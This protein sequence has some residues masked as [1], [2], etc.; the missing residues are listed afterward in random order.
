MKYHRVTGPAAGD[1]KAPYHPARAAHKAQQHA[2]HFIAA[3]VA[4]LRR[5][6]REG[7]AQDTAAG[8]APRPAEPPVIVCPYDAELF[9]HWW[10]E[11]PQWLEAVLRGLDAARSCASDVVVSTTTLGAYAAAH[12]PTTEAELPVSSWGRGGYA[13]V[14]LQPRSQWVHPQL[15]AAE[16]RMLRLARKHPDDSI[17]ASLIHRALNQ[18]ARELM[19]AQ[20]SDWTFILDAGTVT[21]YA[22][23]RINKHLAQF[24]LLLDEI[25]GIRN[26]SKEE[27]FPDLLKRLERQTPFLPELSYRLYNNFDESAQ[28]AV[29]RADRYSYPVSMTAIG[30]TSAQ[31]TNGIPLRI[32]M[33]AWEY[34]P[35]VIGGLARAVC[36]LSKQLA[37]A[38]HMVHV[39]TCHAPDCPV[40]ELS[41][42][43]HVHRVKVLQS[44]QPAAFLDWVF[45]MNMAFSDEI[46]RLIQQFATFDVIHAHDWLVYY[47]A[48]ESK[49]TLGLPLVATIHATEFGRNQ[50]NPETDMGQNIHQLEAKLTIEADHVIACSQFMI[51]E[52]I[53]LFALPADKVSRI[54]NGVQPYR[55]PEPPLQAVN[56]L[57]SAAIQGAGAE[58]RIIGFLGRL[59]QEKGVHLL[60]SA[61][62]LVLK[63]FPRAKLVIAG[64]GPAQES[65]QALAANLGDRVCFTGFLDDNDKLLLLEAAELCVFPSLYEPFGLVALEA[66][67]NRTPLIVSDVGGF[68]EIVEHGIDGR[69]VPANDVSALASEIAAYLA[70]PDLALQL[71]D[72]AAAKVHVAYDWRE[73]STIT[74]EVYYQLTNRLAASSCIIL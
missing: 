29:T 9:G 44:I 19:L 39:I 18:A 16:D 3:R 58:D 61:M 35:R 28:H 73:I 41:E 63:R 60:I 27:L 67:A 49:Q 32:L 40:Y 1:A 31:T 50:G 11:G 38:G 56:P 54:P 30:H 21:E 25:E 69:R 51:E 20:S 13:E 45:Q 70:Q 72:T 36:E 2:E 33:L 10:Y 12:A 55:K 46:H 52:V 68:A 59:V 6:A 74:A 64:T 5:L 37:A 65:L 47:A 34:P 48:K 66:M 43:V 7:E 62:R 53:Q 14:W 71:A 15:H 17:L 4:Q 24:H 23:G 8:M 42:G 26:I 22:T 57:L